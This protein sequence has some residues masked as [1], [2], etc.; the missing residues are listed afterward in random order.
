VHV[1]HFLQLEYV[2]Q[3]RGKKDE[4]SF[5]LNNNLLIAEIPMEVTVVMEDYLLTHFN[6]SK[7]KVFVRQTNTPI[8]EL[9]NIA[10]HAL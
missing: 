3:W 6:S 1:G 9:A 10:N 5:F 8:V 4:N 2:N 7:L